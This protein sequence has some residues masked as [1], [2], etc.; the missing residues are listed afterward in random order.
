MNFFLKKNGL[1][2]R[3]ETYL[4]YYVITC[5]YM[6][7]AYAEEK[8]FTLSESLDASEVLD[9]LTGG[10]HNFLA[11]VFPG[12][13]LSP[14]AMAKAMAARCSITAASLGQPSGQI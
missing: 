6:I 14:H 3:H 12:T 8:D 13:L 5:R 9:A 4:A 11:D 7:R 10:G 2:Q 1:W